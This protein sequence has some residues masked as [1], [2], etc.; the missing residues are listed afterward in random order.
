MA[1]LPD[2]KRLLISLVGS[3]ESPH[4]AVQDLETGSVKAIG[5]ADRYVPSFAGAMHPGVSSDGQHCIL[6]D[7]N[8]YWLQ[9]LDGSA[10]REIHG[11]DAGDTLLEW[12]DDSNNLF[13]LKPVGSDVEIYSLN[14]TSGQRT[15]WT[16]FSPADKTAV[17][18]DSSV[19]ITPD[20]AHYGY[21]VRRI[22]STL[23]LAD[24][25]D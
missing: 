25:L 1:L 15:L 17:A 6:I 19:V 12:H 20:G 18:G 7:G 11:I 4:S 21:M 23:Y 9:P 2:D 14:L 24:G 22:Y 13:L 3:G 10:E 8:H 16:R 5:S